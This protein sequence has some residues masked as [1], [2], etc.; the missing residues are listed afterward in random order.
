MVQAWLADLTAVFFL[1]A[2]CSPSAFDVFGIG[3]FE[4]SWCRHFVRVAVEFAAFF[5][6]RHIQ[7]EDHFGREFTAFFQHRIDGVGI[8][9]GMLGH[10]LEFIF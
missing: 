10:G 1:G 2:E 8:G 7:R 3:V 4:T 9:V 6:A 5:V